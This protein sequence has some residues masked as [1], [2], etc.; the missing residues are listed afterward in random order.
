[1]PPSQTPRQNWAEKRIDEVYANNAHPYFARDDWRKGCLNA[2]MLRLNQ[3]TAPP[4]RPRPGAQVINA[5]S[6]MGG[7]AFATAEDAADYL[8]NAAGRGAAPKVPE[9]LDLSSRVAAPPISRRRTP[10]IAATNT[11]GEIAVALASTGHGM[12]KIVHVPDIPAKEP[13]DDA[14]S[15]QAHS[16]VLSPQVTQ[17]QPRPPKIN[18]PVSGQI[19]HDDLGRG[20][21]GASRDGGARK[22]KGMDLV[23]KPGEAVSSLID[24]K[25]S[26]LGFIHNDSKRENYYVEV[27]GTGKYAGMNVRV[28][29]IAQKS[30]PA[31]G[32]VV[33][34]G[35]SILGLSDDVRVRYGS[36]M[37]PHVHIQV[38]WRGNFI[39]P[40]LVL[41][42][43]P[44]GGP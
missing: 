9:T 22:H 25:V 8:S 33:K 28:I 43:L 4:N 29:Y 31:V 32:T 38:K 15:E 41:P 42:N 24:G 37:K 34:A 19:R 23:T 3:E 14:I 6:L 35:Q 5:T 1:M 20:N 13:V 11:P 16:V 36:R 44:S 21:F 26:K 27:E 39:D 18:L 30:R 2:P 17:G 40:A 10:R 7:D 12:S